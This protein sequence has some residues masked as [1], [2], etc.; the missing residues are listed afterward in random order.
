MTLKELL[1]NYRQDLPETEVKGITQNSKEAGQGYVFFAI[2]GYTVDGHDFIDT[3]IERGAAAII[4]EQ[5]L[6]KVYPIPV[7][8]VADMNAALA[9][10]AC[11]FY[12][13]PAEKLNVIGITGTKGKTSISYLIESILFAAKRT[14]AVF[15]TIN[16]RLNGQKIS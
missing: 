12:G 2:K 14:P 5:D 13:N 10:I 11:R 4:T 9:D 16:Y 7:I 3:V 15:G 1:Q 8:K 6:E